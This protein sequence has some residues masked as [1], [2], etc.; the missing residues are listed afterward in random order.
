MPIGQ[1]PDDLQ[2]NTLCLSLRTNARL[3]KNQGESKGSIHLTCP[4]YPLTRR[5]RTEILPPILRDQAT[6]LPRR[7]PKFSMILMRFTSACIPLF[8][9]E[10]HT[11]IGSYSSAVS[12]QMNP[13]RFSQSGPNQMQ[14]LD[15]QLSLYPSINVFNCRP[16]NSQYHNTSPNTPMRPVYPTNTF[17]S[18]PSA[19]FSQHVPTNY[20]RQSISWQTS[21]G[22]TSHYTAPNSHNFASTTDTHRYSQYSN[23]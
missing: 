23:G 2:P 5:S 16:P 6:N 9:F 11:D 19:R 21:S 3:C 22:P 13:L 4:S 17:N 1:H 20:P 14:V 7:Q 15:C 10:R 12:A 18:D 8:N